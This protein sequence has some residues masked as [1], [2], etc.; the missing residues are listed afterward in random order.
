M[1]L[2]LRGGLVVDP[3]DGSIRRLDVQV[4]D[5]KILAME[6]SLPQGKHAVYDVTDHYVLPG[7]IDVHVHLREPGQAEKETIASGTQ[8]AAAGG[9][10]QIACMPNT[11]PVIDEPEWVRWVVS[12][13]Q[14]HGYAQV[15][16]IAAITK[17][18][19]GQTLTDFVALKAAGAI[20]FSDDGHGVQSASLMREALTQARQIGVPIIVHAE[21]ES[22]SKDGVIHAGH[23]ADQLSLPG[24]H[25][26]AET[27]MIARDVWLAEST[28]AHVHFCHVSPE[29]AVSVI[30]AAKAR[31]VHVTAE[32]T[33]HHLLLTDDE[34]LTQGATAKVNP[35]L[36]SERDR[37]AVV[38]GLL[39]GTLD[40]IATD[41][42][43]HTMEEKSRDL[44][45][46]AFG[47]V[48]LETSMP[49]LYT[50]FVHSG[51]LSLP[52]LVARMSWLP[53]QHLHLDGGRLAVGKRADITVIDPFTECA[54]NPETFLS[55]GRV[56]PFRGRIL[57][58][59]P[60]LTL[61][62]GRVVFDRRGGGSQA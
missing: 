45:Q 25:P 38:N 3:S 49:L 17:G 48:G 59:W 2:L 44:R 60:I 30:R 51:I 35:P 29:S 18:S 32:V 31:G 23:I 13:A 10:T 15:H 46:A 14:Q 43:P 55:K 7:L 61:F 1:G 37:R 33:P 9:F 6:P 62:D 8:A 50:A 41:H 24:I 34:I 54:V 26:D 11:K 57:R 16:P 36:R 4:Q 58:G 22:L 21:E 12:E 19:Q 52:E 20:G 42:A 28:G 27:V 47:F 39:D 5:G 53:A 40:I 56:T